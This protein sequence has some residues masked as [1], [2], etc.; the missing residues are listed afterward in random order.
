LWD[1]DH[2]TPLKRV[3]DV[4]K[5]QGCAAGLQIAHAGL[6]TSASPPFKV[7][8]IESEADDGWPSDIVGPTDLVYAP[9]YGVPRAS[10]KEDIKQ[11]FLGLC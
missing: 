1:D 4:I 10:A 9:H 5:S 11:I 3:V 6:K 8:Y 7:D 2:I